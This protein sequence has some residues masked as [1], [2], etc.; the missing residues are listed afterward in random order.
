MMTM[1]WSKSICSCFF[2]VRFSSEIQ[3]MMDD[4]NNKDVRTRPKCGRAVLNLSRIS[5]LKI[6]DLSF[7]PVPHFVKSCF[8]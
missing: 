1:R 8:D 3:M 5:H 7:C 2:M 4:D 6:F